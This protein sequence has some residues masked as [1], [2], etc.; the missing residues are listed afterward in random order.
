MYPDP[1]ADRGRHEVTLAIRP[2]GA[3]LGEVR[4]AAS[5]L[6][7]PVR[8]TAGTDSVTSP[9]VPVRVLHADGGAADGVE[10]DAVKLADDDTG[11]LIVRVHEALGN[12]VR[13]S[14]DAPGRRVTDA[15]QCN[16]LEE[17]HRG[18]EVGDG[19]ATLTLRPFQLVTLRLRR[20]AD[21]D[22]RTLTD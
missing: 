17:P 22:G 19:I 18:E 3:G 4:A 2:H 13:I 20:S 8:I 14:V 7:Q 15:W 10:I 5:R 1:N 16:L 11:D 12:R 9:M 21:P 6:N